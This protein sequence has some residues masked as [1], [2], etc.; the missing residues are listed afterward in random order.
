MKKVGVIVLI[1]VAIIALAGAIYYFYSNSASANVQTLNGIK[2][3]LLSRDKL[4]L[5]KISNDS[6][7]I[8]QPIGISGGFGL[9][10]WGTN[11]KFE[12]S[13][14]E[15][16]IYLTPK[17]VK[18]G[19][20]QTVAVYPISDGPHQVTIIS[21]KKSLSIQFSASGYDQSNQTPVPVVPSPTA[22]I[23]FRMQGDEFPT[24]PAIEKLNMLWNESADLSVSV[25]SSKTSTDDLSLY[26]ED[27]NY[28]SVYQT[29]ESGQF[30]IKGGSGREGTVNLV[31]EAGG[32]KKKLPISFTRLVP[33]GIKVLIKTVRGGGDEYIMSTGTTKRVGDKFT[34]VAHW[35]ESDGVESPVVKDNSIASYVTTGSGRDGM[36]IEVTPQKIGST[37]IV[38]KHG[39]DTLAYKLKVE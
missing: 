37:K 9:K 17:N 21:G 23:V 20:P 15:G 27:N 24:S 31:A 3:D 29:G 34:L 5:K 13:S 14:G 22:E 30:T 28:G 26:L 10:V 6:Y 16:L 7:A 19:T 8:T 4:S 32:I 11:I 25:D 33:S 12:V 1:V 35:P 2:F 38:F 36:S 39:N 18:K